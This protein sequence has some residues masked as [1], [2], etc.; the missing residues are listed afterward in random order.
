MTDTPKKKRKFKITTPGNPADYDEL[1]AH[2]MFK[3]YEDAPANNT[4][5]ASLRKAKDN[6]GTNLFIT[7]SKTG[8]PEVMES[9]KSP[10]NESRKNINNCKC[11][12][13][14]RPK[15]SL[16]ASICSSVAST[17]AISA[18]GSP[19]AIRNNV[20]VNNIT[21]ITTGIVAIKRRI[22]YPCNKHSRGRIYIWNR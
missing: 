13:L 12:G 7:N 4:A 3:A 2:R 17:P 14:F 5:N 10:I 20:K 9:P 19:G 6:V 1:S 15:E 11:K 18:A 21:T 8:F 16:I 22:M